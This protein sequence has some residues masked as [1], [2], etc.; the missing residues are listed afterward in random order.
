[1]RDPVRIAWKEFTETFEIKDGFTA[2]TFK[3]ET[4]VR[5]GSADTEG[6]VF[7]VSKIAIK[8]AKL[9]SDNAGCRRQLWGLNV[10]SLLT[11]EMHDELK[12]L[13]LK[14]AF[15]RFPLDVRPA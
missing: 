7:P 11:P 12:G 2:A 8:C 13:A 6:K 3:L 15:D 10:F 5:F 1:M 4:I 14:A 9:I